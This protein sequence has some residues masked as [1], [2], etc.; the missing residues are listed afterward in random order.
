MPTHKQGTTTPIPGAGYGTSTA[1]SLGSAD[2]GMIKSSFP[3][4]PLNTDDQLTDDGSSSPSKMAD[5]FTTNVLQAVINDGGH[6]FGTQNM[7]WSQ[8]IPAGEISNDGGGAPANA[9]VP[10]TVSPGEGSINPS[11]QAPAPDALA[12]VSP[13]EPPGVGVGS[14][15]GISDSSAT[16]N[17]AAI[18]TL[19]SGNSPYGE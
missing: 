17:L 15:L 18:G 12:D 14:A 13:S 6:T 1:R 8:N 2:H 3:G 10:N 16:Q 19:S 5:W 4:S 9:H 11:D 7:D